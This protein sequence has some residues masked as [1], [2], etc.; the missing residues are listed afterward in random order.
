L[1]TSTGDEPISEQ[2]VVEMFAKVYDSVPGQAFLMA[3]PKLNEN[4]KRL[5][6]RY[7]ISLIEARDRDEASTALKALISHK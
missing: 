1:A 7:K 6:K 4:G 3:I 5:A 2:S